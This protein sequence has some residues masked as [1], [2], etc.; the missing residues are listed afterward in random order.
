MERHPVP[1]IGMN[2]VPHG[3]RRTARRDS[4]PAEAPTS[5]DTTEL[6]QIALV[7]PMNLGYEGLPREVRDDGA[8]LLAQIARVMRRRSGLRVSNLGAV[9]NM[10]AADRASRAIER[11]RPSANV[12]LPLNGARADLQW[13]VLGAS[14]CPV[15]VWARPSHAARS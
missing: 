12:A 5:R 8:R 4:R 13:R 14:E 15:L 2:D 9:A 10:G 11:G 7:G 3:R 6:L 1:R